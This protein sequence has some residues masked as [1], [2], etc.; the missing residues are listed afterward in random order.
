ML[1]KIKQNYIGDRAFYKNLMIILLPMVIQQGISSSVA[2]LDNIMVGA[3]GTEAISGVAIVNQLMF[4]FNLTI[5]GGLAGISI[6]GA[7]F[8]GISDFKGMQHA[9]RLKMYFG[10]A[11]TLIGIITFWFGGKNLIGLYLTESDGGNIALTLQ[12]AMKY[13]RVSLLGLLPFVLVQ[14]YTSSIR[15]TGETIIPMQ[16]SII[17]I[18]LNLIFNYIFIFGKLGMPAMGAM[19]AAWGTVIAR[20]V[21]MGYLLLRAHGNIERFV[22]LQGAFRQ[23]SVPLVLV[24]KVART[25]T[26]LLCN[27]VFWSIGMAMISQAYST[28]GLT[29]VAATNINSTIWNAF[30]ILMFAMGNAIA[31]I[32]GQELGAGEI[33][34]AKT[35]DRKLIFFTVVSHILIGI[36]IILLAG[37]IPQIYNTTNEVREL[38]TM[39]LVISGFALPIDAFAHAAYFTIRSGGKTFIT[40][41]FDCCFTCLV[42]LPIAYC[43]CHFTTLEIPVIYACVTFVNIIKVIIGAVMLHKGVWANNIIEH[44]E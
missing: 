38:T 28:R 32:I 19:G 3:L 43:L 14:I 5:F 4:V 18:L 41:L 35:D 16:S 30:C 1:A 6:F 26:P 2:L 22:F 11:I 13:L 36:L 39:L 10:I 34:K 12:E 44:L 31:I 40:F 17:A 15:E 25:A 24:K 7:Q 9:F 42:N 27:E 37:L 33:E 23:L 20:F 21:E 29:V 8:Y